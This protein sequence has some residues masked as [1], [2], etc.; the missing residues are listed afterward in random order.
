MTKR[1]TA[2]GALAL[3]LLGACHEP[4]RQER[5]ARID[6]ACAYEIDPSAC[7]SRQMM[8]LMEREASDRQR[9]IDRAAGTQ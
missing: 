4:T 9:E 2:A 8:R 3:L 6:Q 1:T 5:L 7:R